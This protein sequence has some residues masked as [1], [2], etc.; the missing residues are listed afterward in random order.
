MQTEHNLREQ[1]SGIG[2]LRLKVRFE[3]TRS[4]DVDVYI[5]ENYVG[6]FV[7]PP[8][9]DFMTYKLPAG[10]R[11]VRVEASNNGK[12]DTSEHQVLILGDEAR[13]VIET[14]LELD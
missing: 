11:T 3:K 7:P 6:K 2:E 12:K 9:S 4:T 8:N 5:D 1:V 10:L 13:Q 14:Q